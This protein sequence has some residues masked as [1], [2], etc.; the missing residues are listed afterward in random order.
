MKKS[1]KIRLKEPKVRDYENIFD[2]IRESNEAEFIL[3][4]GHNRLYHFT[5]Y[6]TTFS[7]YNSKTGPINFVKA[8]FCEIFGTEKQIEKTRLKLEKIIGRCELK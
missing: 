5:N 6:G 1:F 2:N 3:N 8:G 7:I 4:N